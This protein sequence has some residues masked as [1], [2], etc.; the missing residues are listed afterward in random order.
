MTGEHVDSSITSLHKLVEHCDYG[1]LKDDMIRD[2]IVVGLVDEQ[3]PEEKL[4]L[5]SL[6]PSI[7]LKR[8]VRKQQVVVRCNPPGI[9]TNVNAMHSKPPSSRHATTKHQKTYM[10]CIWSADWSRLRA[11]STIVE[12]IQMSSMSWH[13]GRALQ[14]CS[15]W[16]CPAF[17]YQR[18]KTDSFAT[19]GQNKERYEKDGRRRCNRES[20]ITHWLVF[21]YGRGPEERWRQDLC[22][23]NE[24]ERKC[25]P[26]AT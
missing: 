17:R 1:A 10:N 14:N 15:Q 3:L 8:A 21:T 16:W 13:D 7:T 20:R 25:T 22:R 23:L 26:W 9:T 24:V 11:V 19:D 5:E 2:K 12:N 6:D 18:P 4:Q